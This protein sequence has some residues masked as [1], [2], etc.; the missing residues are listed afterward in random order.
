M[1]VEFPGKMVALGTVTPF[2]NPTIQQGWGFMPA[3]VLNGVGDI[4]IAFDP[5]YLIV[6]TFAT[7]TKVYAASIAGLPPATWVDQGFGTLPNSRRFLFF[8]DAGAAVDVTAIRMAV[9]DI[10]LQGFFF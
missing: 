9:F 8:D 3:G 1:A 4:D 6:D 10:P 7:S 2:L 5:E